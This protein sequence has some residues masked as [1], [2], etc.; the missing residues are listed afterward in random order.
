MNTELIVVLPVSAK[1][2]CLGEA[3]NCGCGYGGA[4]GGCPQV[5]RAVTF[6]FVGQEEGVV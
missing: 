6:M 4:K 1:I 3:E 2:F 5:G